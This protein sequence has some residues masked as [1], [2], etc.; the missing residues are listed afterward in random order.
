MIGSRGDVVCFSFQGT[1]N[2][3]AGE[4]GAIVT[5]DPEV[6]QR[7][8]DLRLLD[9]LNDSE[10]RYA[11]KRSWEFDVNEQ[12]WRYHMSDLMA[13]IGRVQ[14]RRFPAEMKPR[15][16]ALGRRY[17]ELLASVEHL[18]LLDIDF[19]EV[20]PHIFPVYVT[21]GRRDEIRAALAERDIETG[22]HYKP[23]HL[24]TMY[25]GAERYPVAE[26]LYDEMLTLP[27]HPDLTE[28]QQDEIVAVVRSFATAPG[29]TAARFA[30]PAEH[31][32]AP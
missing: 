22:I 14:L 5:A 17:Q 19:G 23:N 8:R 1:K 12:G 18:R 26:R 29:A 15:R 21:N 6:A 7:A 16:V 27:L 9:V 13:A 20:V 30:V 3:T 24:L 25:A 11:G 4:G 28:E 31:L 10:N 32:P 2:I